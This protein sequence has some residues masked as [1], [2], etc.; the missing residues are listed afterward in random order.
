[1]QKVALVITAQQTLKK[2][3]LRV[4]TD[5]TWFSRLLRH[6]GQGTERVYSFNPRARTGLLIA[7]TVRRV[8]KAV[9]NVHIYSTE[10]QTDRERG[11]PRSL[12]SIYTSKERPTMLFEYVR[13]STLDLSTHTQ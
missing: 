4:R 5:R 9:I 12:T 8:V 2:H 3:R 7:R 11:V 1:M 6:S 13:Y 10:R